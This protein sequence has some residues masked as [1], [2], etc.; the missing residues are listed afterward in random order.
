[1]YFLVDIEVFVYKK[2]FISEI[3]SSKEVRC[4]PLGPG[5]SI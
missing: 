2:A 4:P 5:G 3:L 1:M